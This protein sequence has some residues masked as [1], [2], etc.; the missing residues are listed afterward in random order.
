MATITAS[1]TEAGS[2]RQNDRL[3]PGGIPASAIALS[4][5]PFEQARV[6]PPSCYTEP[7]FFRFEVETVLKKQWI[8]AGRVDQ[9]ANAGDYFTLTRY[10]EP[11]IILRDF[12]G[13]IRAM[14]GVCRHRAYPVASGAG[15][16]GKKGFHCPYHGWRYR[17]DGSLAAAPYMQPGHKP[18]GE[19][20]PEFAVDIWQGFIFINFDREAE[21]V[22]SSLKTLDAVLEPF[23][24]AEM[25]SSVMREIPWTGNWKA[26]LDNFTEAYHQPFVHPTTFEP[27]APARLGV[28]EDV[29]GPY[30]LFWLP[31]PDGNI[32]LMFDEIPGLPEMHRT[33]FIVVNI[34]PMFHMLIDPSCIVI[35]DMDPHSV[36]RLTARWDILVRP[37]AF[38]LP[39]FEA[40]RD[41]L[42]RALIPTW[43]E[44]EEACRTIGQGQGSQ[45]ATQGNFSWMEKSVHQFHSWMATQYL[46]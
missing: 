30:N 6:L 7:D 40:R 34:F 17:L 11:A 44:D 25:K 3:L 21:P 31:A 46:K 45:F 2:E 15:N 22:S 29:D 9:V 28:Y 8:L 5:Q 41:A 39:D 27:M 23:G 13:H 32:D 4:R 14:S 43:D 16:C 12:E 20:L 42:T 10:A 38:E 36:N 18:D 26:T 35:L 24:M 19:G 33:S 37:E 1:P